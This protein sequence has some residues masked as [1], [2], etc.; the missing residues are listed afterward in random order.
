MRP[1][2]MRRRNRGM[3]QEIPIAVAV[4]LIAVAV[5]MDHVGITG[6]TLLVAVDGLALMA[7]FYYY[8]LAPGWH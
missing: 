5:L 4:V 1:Q 7:L 2:A 8:I 3:L 6:K